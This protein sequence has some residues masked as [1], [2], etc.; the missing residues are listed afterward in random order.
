MVVASDRSANQQPRKHRYAMAPADLDYA[1]GNDVLRHIAEAD[2]RALGEIRL[3]LE[4]VENQLSYVR[5]IAQGRIDIAK[6]ELA[7]RSAGQ[8]RSDLSDVIR[9]LPDVL[10]DKKDQN[11]LARPIDIE[12]D[13]DPEYGIELDEVVPPMRMLDIG[14]L[15]RGDLRE[16]VACLESI[17]SLISGHRRIVHE[18]LDTVHIATAGRYDQSLR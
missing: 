4:N 2:K 10:C 3:L 11:G 18:R 15:D 17:E 9:R 8:S 14:R 12:I 16:M 1:L 5:R 6:S 7:V 13:P